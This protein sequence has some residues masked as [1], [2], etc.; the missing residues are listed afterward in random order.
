MFDFFLNP[1]EK[2]FLIVRFKISAIFVQFSKFN[3]DSKTVNTKKKRF[4]PKKTKYVLL[5]KN[6]NFELFF[7]YFFNKK[8][9][10]K[11]EKISEKSKNS[12]KDVGFSNLFSNIKKKQEF[13]VF[14]NFLNRTRAS[15]FCQTKL[16]IFSHFSI[17]F[18]IFFKNIKIN[19][20]SIFKKTGQ[21]ET[22][23]NI[24]SSKI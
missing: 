21:L 3:S 14:F 13:S 1:N 22:R 8:K 18:E 20:F 15:I 7:G 10:E 11:P 19:F 23:V 4:F 17:I 5:G 12:T 16:N 24:F 9:F 2:L 6:H